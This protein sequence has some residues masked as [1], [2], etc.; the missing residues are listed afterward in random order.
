MATRRR[1]GATLGEVLVV[2]G[3]LAAM[4]GLLLPAV[5]KVREAAARTHGQNQL[6]QLALAAHQF[7]AQ[8]SG[9]LPTDVDP[10]HTPFTVRLVPHLGGLPAPQRH[11]AM[12]AF[13]NPA[14]P[15]STGPIAAGV[16]EVSL[17]SYAG[18]ALAFREKAPATSL[19]TSFSD[20]AAH[21]VLFGE[22]YAQCGS[23]TFLWKALPGMGM[24][25]RPVIGRIVQTAMEMN[26]PSVAIVRTSDGT[27]ATFQVRPCTMP[28]SQLLHGGQTL[29]QTCGSR[30]I[31]DGSLAQT[32][33]ISG[34]LVALADG[35][36]RLIRPGVD[37]DTYWAAFTPA[38][39]EVL[40]DW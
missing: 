22:H 16:G 5:Q 26:D 18:N 30:P 3:I 2:V 24:Y 23:S 21:T 38:G 15:T 19:A 20:G 10:Y 7:A 39:G 13:I 12:P 35:S 36:V 27:R 32:P 11:Y 4:L 37:P 9:R 31:C 40:G 29:A 34:A 17:A 14:D 8:H 28:E 33:Y 6:K 1:A 25:M